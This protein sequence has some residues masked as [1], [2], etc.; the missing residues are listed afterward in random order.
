MLIFLFFSFGGT[1][2]KKA[3]HSL[4]RKMN[5]DTHKKGLCII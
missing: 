2:K 1:E 3:M 4:S 5:M